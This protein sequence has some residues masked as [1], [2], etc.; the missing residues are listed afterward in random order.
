MLAHLGVATSSRDARRGIT[1]EQRAQRLAELGVQDTAVNIRNK[2]M[3][4]RSRGAAV[5]QFEGG[6]PFLTTPEPI[7][8][9]MTRALAENRTRYAPSSELVSRRLAV[10]R[11]A[12]G[13]GT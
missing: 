9:A 13:D 1:Y 12:A 10:L 4:L 3:E 2:V 7:K 6:E 8:E 11:Y 5:Y